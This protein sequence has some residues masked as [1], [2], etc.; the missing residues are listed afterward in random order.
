[1]SRVKVAVLGSGNIGTDLMMKLSRS[2][3]LELTTVIGIDPK[4]D[5]LKRAK[6]LGY[7]TIDN[8]IDGF[9]ERPEL[10]D[11]VFDATSAKAHIRNAKLL[12][13]AGIKSN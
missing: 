10:A 9:M 1:M 11:I 7:V 2:T 8:G 13:E 3:V 5:G 6:E 12:K 4:S